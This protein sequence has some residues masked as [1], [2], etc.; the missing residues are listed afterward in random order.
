ML[1][2]TIDRYAYITCRYLPPFFENRHRLVYS[3]IENCQNAVQ[4]KHP[5]IRECIKYL[6]CKKGLEI[7]HQGDLPARSGMG[8]SSSFI[9]GLLL[10]LYALRGVYKNKYDL[11]KEAIHIEQNLMKEN[12]GS[13]DQV[14]AAV[15]GLNV[16]EFEKN[17]EIKINPIPVNHNRRKQLN[18]Q[19]QLYFTGFQRNATDIVS[20]YVSDLNLKSRALRLLKE[21]VNEGVEILTGSAP[22]SDFGRLMHESW[23]IKKTIGKSVSNNNIDTLYHKAIEAGA[24]GG[25]LLGAGGGGFMLLSVEEDKQLQVR[26]ALE[27]LILVP[28]QLEAEGA[29]IIYHLPQRSNEGI[30]NQ[31]NISALRVFEETNTIVR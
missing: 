8:S 13:Q 24:T 9:V 29:K 22:I 6:N 31:N 28:F 15:G 12:V 14:A 11:F 3:K 18:N 1:S 7:I 21:L 19:L 25:K 2:T 30:E 4:I 5:G 23:L 27:D 26:E 10:A 17:E 16:I 20:S